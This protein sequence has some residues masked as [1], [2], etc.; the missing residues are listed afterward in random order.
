MVRR[1]LQVLSIGEANSYLV[2]SENAKSSYNFGLELL[3]LM[4]AKSD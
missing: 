2:V 1:V 3:K 4:E